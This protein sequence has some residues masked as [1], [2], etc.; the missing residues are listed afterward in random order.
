[1]QL[2]ALAVSLLSRFPLVQR[3]ILP[4]T[5][6]ATT[7]FLPAPL[8]RPHPGP[9]ILPQLHLL[10]PVLQYAPR[11]LSVDLPAPRVLILDYDAGGHVLELHGRGRLVDFLAAGAAAFKEVFYDMA[12]DKRR[13]RG[14][15]LGERRRRCV[16]G[17]AEAAKPQEAHA[18]H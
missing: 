16:E 11:H 8:S 10:N 7:G 13:A 3:P 12:V 17:I 14:H 4:P 18:R 5:F 1:M 6:L 2:P 9:G 15:R